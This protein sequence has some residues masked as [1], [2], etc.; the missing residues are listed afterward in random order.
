M[1]KE[2]T[3]AMGLSI[4]ELGALPEV[5]A[6]AVENM[7]CAA[8][9]T[10]AGIGEVGP[11]ISQLGPLGQGIQELVARYPSAAEDFEHF[12]TAISTPHLTRWTDDMIRVDRDFVNIAQAIAQ[13]FG[14][15]FDQAWQRLA[16]VVGF[17]PETWPYN[18]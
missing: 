6:P 17:D 4:P 7:L 13:R 1:C 18:P 10:I 9:P 2:F 11:T 12:R 14:I 15:T 16:Q 5:A 3:D 8:E